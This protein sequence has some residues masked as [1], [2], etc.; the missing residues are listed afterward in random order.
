MGTEKRLDTNVPGDF[1]VTEACINCDQCRQLAPP[2]FSEVGDYSAVISQPWREEDR[3]KA[4]H[5]LLS[6]PT[7]AIGS[8]RKEGLTEAI[9]DFPLLIENNVFYCGFTS[10][11]SYGASS[12]FI[13][14]PTGNWLVDAPRWAPQLVH[15]FEQLGGIRYIFLTHQDD[16][17]DAEKYAEK[18]NAER[19]IHVLEKNSQ[20]GAEHFIQDRTAVDWA[21]DFR[22]I[23]VPGHTKGHMVLLYREKYL[24]TGDHLAW[25]RERGQLDANEDFCWYSWKE[26]G[27]SMERLA[28]ERFE[29]ILPGHGDRVYL[30]ADEMNIAMNQLLSRMK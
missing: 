20:P 12:Y 14:H 9:A 5:A 21:P 8:E 24:F 17:A 30:E 29:W 19:I 4:F 7:G 16:V 6:C 2:I 26:Q 1:Y 11:K 23:P 27:E 13:K 3:T 22:I 28:K 18:F 15:K 25:D 10:R